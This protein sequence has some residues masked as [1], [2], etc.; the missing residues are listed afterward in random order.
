MSGDLRTKVETAYIALGA[1]LGDRVAFMREA[2]SMLE[3]TLSTRLRASR[4][5]ETEARLDEDQPAFL[6][7]VVAA[8]VSMSP[9]AL[10]DV[11]QEIEAT[12]GRRR[13]PTRPKGPR[14]IDL[15]LLALG[16]REMT[17]PRLRLPH[18]GVAA[19][20]FVLAPWMDLAPSLEI[21]GTNATVAALLARC[22]DTG[23]VHPID[24]T[25]MAA[26]NEET[27]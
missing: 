22:P 25:L 2:T 8:P 27:A 26:D 5:Y 6:N 14:V 7:A 4:I 1:N 10:L 16:R 12:L 20:R 17:H 11:L 9:L 15:D 3:A 24:A 13:D 23:W 19:R 18:P 21:P